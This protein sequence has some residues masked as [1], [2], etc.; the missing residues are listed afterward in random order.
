M[1]HVLTELWAERPLSINLKNIQRPTFNIQGGSEP[2]LSPTISPLILHGAR[3][4]TFPRLDDWQALD[5]RVEP[6]NRSS[7][8]PEAPS[9]FQGIKF[10]PP[11]VGCYEACGEGI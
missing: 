11:N 3:E 10:E 6:L 2:P 9:E 8:R 1:R 4:T 7:R 5:S